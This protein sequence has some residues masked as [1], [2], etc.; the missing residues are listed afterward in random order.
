V[1]SYWNAKKFKWGT[2]ENKY[3]SR[4]II[5]KRF[6]AVIPTASWIKS[7]FKWCS[8]EYIT[9]QWHVIKWVKIEKRESIGIDDRKRRIVRAEQF[10][11]G[12]IKPAFRGALA[13]L[14][15]VG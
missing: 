10:T 1:E 6:K 2:I 5:R 8:E 15:D 14:R 12:L 11:N 7:G 3:N 9:A 4:S 13:Y